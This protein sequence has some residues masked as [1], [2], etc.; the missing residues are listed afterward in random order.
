[1]NAPPSDSHVLLL[2]TT[3]ALLFLPSLPCPAPLCLLHSRAPLILGP[4]SVNRHE[5]KGELD[6]AARI[7]WLRAFSSFH[8][9]FLFFS[10][11]FPL[12]QPSNSYPCLF[13]YLFLLFPIFLRTVIFLSTISCFWASFPPFSFIFFYSLFL[14][15][16]LYVY[17]LYI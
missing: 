10:R 11:D 12:G 1:M 7:L 13:V 14:F 17:C 3:S 15:L 5:G 2:L 9:S 8:L 6:A 4:N 16:S